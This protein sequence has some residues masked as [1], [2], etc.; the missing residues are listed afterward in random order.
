MK[1][2]FANSIHNRSNDKQRLNTITIRKAKLYGVP[3]GIIYTDGNPSQKYS[4]EG[5][6]KKYKK[7]ELMFNT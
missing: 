4:Y 1:T 5:T 7:N 2:M 3:M 6:K